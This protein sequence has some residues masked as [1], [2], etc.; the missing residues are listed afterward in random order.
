MSLPDTWH[1][2]G[3]KIRYLRKANGLTLKQLARGCNL[4]ANTISM[5]ERS[6]VSPTIET[7]CKIAHALGVSP[8]SLFLEIC[9]TAVVLQRAGEEPLDG[10]LPQ[11]ALHTLTCAASRSGC[12]MDAASPLRSS[13]LCLSGEIELELDGQTYLLAPGDNLAF[14]SDAYHRWHNNSPTTGIAVLVLSG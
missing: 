4:S 2:V 8:S 5:V 10:S 11:Q 6:E 3:S 14:N 1:N 9:Q 12:G 7:I 13:I